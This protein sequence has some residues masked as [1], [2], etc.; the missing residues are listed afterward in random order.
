MSDLV[1]SWLRTVVPGL[2]AAVLAP[3]LAWAAVHIPWVLDLLELLNIDPTSAEFTAGVVL[4][5][6][7]GWYAAWRRLEPHIPDWLTRV[8]LGSSKAPTYAPVNADGAY[9][10]TDLSPE[11]RRLVNDLRAIEDDADR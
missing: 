10:I 7:A 3:V 1:A 2:Y 8:V 9:V 11:E 6:L 4:V 5:V